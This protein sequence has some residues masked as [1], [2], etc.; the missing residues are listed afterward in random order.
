M[1]FIDFNAIVSEAWQAYDASREILHIEDIS[2]KV[3]TNHVYRITLRDSNFIVAKLSY[4]GKF[5]HF[6]EDHSI[7]NSLSNNLPE[8]YENVL[9]RSLMKGSELFVHRHQSEII[10]AWVVFYRPIKIRNKLPRK[11]NDEQIMMLGKEMAKFHK[12]CDTVKGTLPH[13]AKTMNVDIDDLLHTLQTPEGKFE[14]RSHIGLIQE[15]CEL[16]KENYVSLNADSLQ[17]MPVFVDWNI[18]NFSLTPHFKL[19]SRWD[20]DWFRMSSRVMDFYFFSRV[21]SEIGDRTIFSYNVDV[22]MQDRFLLFLKTYHKYYPLSEQEILLIKEAYRF[23]LL[24]YV[25]KYGRY[26]FH[27]L[28]ANK[29][30]KE[31]YLEHLPALDQ[32]FNPKPILDALNL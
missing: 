28:F 20:Y 26:F 29:L 17:A 6:V 12:A 15:Q 1:G 22:L 23:F 9:A 32:K 30:Q 13:S 3:S 8:P 2:A 10:D 7:I 25:V 18:G 24:T 19:Y 11:L 16:F 14:Y 21:V 27:E 5:E 31:A 4:F